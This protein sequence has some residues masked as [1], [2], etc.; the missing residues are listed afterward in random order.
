[1]QRQIVLNNQKKNHTRWDIDCERESID[2]DRLIE[3]YDFQTD[4]GYLEK[5]DKDD[6]IQRM[7][8]ELT[9]FQKKESQ[10]LKLK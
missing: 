9:Q 5:E 3:L 4:H 2:S 6:L 8:D 7:I 10:K 1:M